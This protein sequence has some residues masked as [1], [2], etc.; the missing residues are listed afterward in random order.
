MFF[1]PAQS[2]A[3]VKSKYCKFKEL[4]SAGCSTKIIFKFP[5]FLI[6]SAKKLKQGKPANEEKQIVNENEK[7]QDTKEQASF[8]VYGI[9]YI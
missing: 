5:L 1:F 6:G 8:C 4:I 3:L 7:D 2:N 9:L